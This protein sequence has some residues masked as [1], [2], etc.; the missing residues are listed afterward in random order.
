MSQ[1]EHPLVLEA[2]ENLGMVVL[3]GPILADVDDSVEEEVAMTVD[4]F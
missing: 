4:D 1:P 2:L 3:V